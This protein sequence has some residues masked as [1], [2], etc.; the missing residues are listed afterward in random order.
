MTTKLEQELSKLKQSDHVCSIYETRGE[1]LAVSVA[2]IIDGLARG[3]RWSYIVDDSTIEEV[4][5][6]LSAAGVDVE[7]ARQRS[8]LRIL[9]RQDTCLSTGEFVPQAL[10][11]F[12]RQAEAEALADGFSGL[13]QMGE[14]TWMLGPEPGCDRL[15]EFEVLVDQWIANSKTVG[16]CHYNRPRFDAPCIHDVI[17]T[18]PLVILGDQ[19]CPNPYHKSPESVLSTDQ[20]GT[21]PEFK[22]KQ[23]D[24][25]I[26]KLKRASSAEQAREHA[27]EE[28]K[29]SERRL[30][31]AQK[32]AHIGSWE[33]DLRTNQIT[34]TDELYR[35]FGLQSHQ[36]DI[37]YQQFL[38][39]LWPQ[40]ADRIR[41]LADETICERRHFDC[42]YRITL[43]DG[44]VRVL[45][46][47]G[48][49]I[50]DEEGEPVRL[51]GTAQDVTELRQA[52][53]A[54]KSTRV[55]SRPSPTGCSKCRR[56][57]AAAWPASFMTKSGR[58]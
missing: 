49:V 43:P 36:G 31:E 11:D 58:R 8:A 35:L 39:L 6:A 48:S 5:Q 21:T 15:I 26:A 27:L 46:D 42:D 32:V 34:W 13:R 47:R 3:E 41:T 17:R 28:L 7:Q 9:T 20:T 18:H 30:A 54:R 33:R 2:F 10:F 25:W 45:N 24:W 56:K 38:D 57:S 4:V 50:L 12:L 51:V 16:M 22:A 44:S 14:M 1:Q 23:L 53:H 52:E 37:S 29:Q 40:D 55:G 19:L